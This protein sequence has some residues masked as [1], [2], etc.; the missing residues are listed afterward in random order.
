GERPRRPD[1]RH[2]A[3]GRRGNDRRAAAPFDEGLAVEMN[4]TELY[5]CDD[6]LD[7][8]A[9]PRDV[10]SSRLHKALV[11][12]GP[13]VETGDRPPQWVCDGRVMGRSGQGK[14]A[15]AK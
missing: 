3:P 8:Y 5:S 12:R 13:R 14:S 6:H 10:W 2:R 1:H 9:V 15:V 4:A 7:L 11:E